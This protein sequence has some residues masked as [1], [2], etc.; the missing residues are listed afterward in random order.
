MLI[1]V[2]N[3]LSLAIIGIATVIGIVIAPKIS[4]LPYKL[5]MVYLI[6][7]FINS[8]ALNITGSLQIRNHFIANIYMYLRFPML[9]W[10][11]YLLFKWQKSKGYYLSVLLWLIT[12]VF[13]I[14]GLVDLGGNQLH[15]PY[16]VAGSAIIIVVILL[17]F[18]QLFKSEMLVS[19]LHYPFFLTSIGLFFFFLLLMPSRGIINFLITSNMVAGIQ[20]SIILQAYN[21]ILYSLIGIDF[22]IA[23]KQTRKSASLSLQ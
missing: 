14:Y 21:C 15:T 16:V 20:A 1:S 17:Y 23:W 12:P 4:S 9:A 10:I 2:L 22:I 18:Y 19:P 11:Y 6:I 7:T 8:T 5:L 13:L 3:I